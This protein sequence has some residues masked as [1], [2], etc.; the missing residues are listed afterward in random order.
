MLLVRRPSPANTHSAKPYLVIFDNAQDPVL[1]NP[2]WP[3]SAMGSVLVTTLDL[4]FKT[5]NVAENGMA[6]PTIDEEDAV[7]M[8]FDEVHPE[9]F[10]SNTDGDRREAE[11]IV[12]RVG[13]PPLAVQNCVGAINAVKRTLKK[14]SARYTQPGPILEQW[15]VGDVS[16]SW[17]P[18]D[19]A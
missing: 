14:Y 11:T 10:S 2:W 5:N 19:Q 17:A 8:A 15:S 13:C 9:A 3:F 12:K 1:T 4:F 18:Y 6:L 16:R 7:K